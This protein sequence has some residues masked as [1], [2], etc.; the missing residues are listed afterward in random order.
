MITTNPTPQG[1][2]SPTGA[3][4]FTGQSGAGA[5]ASSGLRGFGASSVAVDAVGALGQGLR[6][7]SVWYEDTPVGES[8]VYCYVRES[9]RYWIGIASGLAFFTLSMVVAG[10]TGLSSGSVP[11]WAYMALILP[12]SVAATW[13]W[14]YFPDLGRGGYYPVDA[15]GH[16]LP[17]VSKAKLKGLRWAGV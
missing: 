11:L 1:P 4:P 2:G 6:L 16:L 14:V 17:K 12:T 13:L 10:L 5:P 8:P 15:T 3:R 7:R 9:S